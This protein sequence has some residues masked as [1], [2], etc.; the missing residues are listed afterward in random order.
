MG[1]GVSG[2]PSSPDRSQPAGAHVGGAAAGMAD[3]GAAAVLVEPLAVD[4]HRGGD[5]E[6]RHRPVDQRLEQDRGAE[7]VGAHVAADLVHGLADADFG[8]QVEHAVDAG[9]GAPDRVGVANVGLDELDPVGRRRVTAAV[10]LLDERVQHPYRVS[11]GLQLLD[12]RAPDEAAPS[13]DQ[14][15]FHGLPAPD[16]CSSTL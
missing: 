10:N 11:L 13:G 3:A 14:I 8:R 1:T 16:M 2:R 6:A 7:V 9:G 4:A 12:E 15:A 5:D